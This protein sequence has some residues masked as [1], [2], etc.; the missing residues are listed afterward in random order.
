M[1][2]THKKIDFLQAVVQALAVTEVEFVTGRAENWAGCQPARERYDLV[3]AHAVRHS[4][5]WLSTCY[6]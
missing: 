6:P 3:T 4:T 2:G 1:D 5:R